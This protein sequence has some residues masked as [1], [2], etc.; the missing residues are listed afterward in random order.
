MHA[1]GYDDFCLHSNGGY[2]V[3]VNHQN[4]ISGKIEVSGAKNAALL[5]LMST[6]L[7]DG[8]HKFVNG[9]SRYKL[10]IVFA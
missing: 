8:Q 2:L 4:P 6:I 9:A 1:V 7:T 3:N 10:Y 5:I